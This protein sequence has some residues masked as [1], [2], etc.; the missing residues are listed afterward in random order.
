[1]FSSADSTQ[2]KMSLFQFVSRFLTKK[3]TTIDLRLS[4]LEVDQVGMRIKCIPHNKSLKVTLEDGKWHISCFS[5]HVQELHT[6]KGK[7]LFRF[8]HWRLLFT[9]RLILSLIDN[10]A[11]NANS[12]AT[13]G[14]VVPSAAGGAVEV[15]SAVGISQNRA[16]TPL[17]TN[18]NGLITVSAAGTNS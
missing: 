2:P 14:A 8:Y 12:S 3:A 13:A 16:Q 4:D 17:S 9:Y 5:R 10:N 7:D 11:E 15:S 6:F 1:M 18:T